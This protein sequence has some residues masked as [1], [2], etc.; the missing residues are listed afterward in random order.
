M[1]TKEQVIE[2]LDKFK[3]QLNEFEEI[4]EAYP[5][6]MNHCINSNDSES[7]SY[8]EAIIS[9]VSSVEILE[10]VIKTDSSHD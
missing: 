5:E 9:L 6:K 7:L 4:I 2:R 10:W 3:Q 1:K 8:F